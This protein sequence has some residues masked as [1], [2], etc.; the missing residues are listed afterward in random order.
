MPDCGME[1]K[2]IKAGAWEAFCNQLQEIRPRTRLTIE[3]IERDGSRVRVVD[4]LELTEAH[5]D[6]N[7]RCNDVLNFAFTGEN[8]EATEY[9][10]TEPIHIKLRQENSDRYNEIEIIAEDGTHLL[11]ARP[12]FRQDLIRDL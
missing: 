5:L 9:A 6:P 3:R 10:I 11:S 4:N 8:G 12:G 1:T 7:D 2:E